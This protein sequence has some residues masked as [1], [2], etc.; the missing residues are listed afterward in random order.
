MSEYD[1]YIIKTAC[2]HITCNTRHSKSSDIHTYMY[3]HLPVYIKTV[4]SFLIL[5]TVLVAFWTMLLHSGMNPEIKPISFY[6]Q[7]FTEFLLHVHILFPVI[8]LVISLH[9][10]LYNYQQSLAVSTEYCIVHA[11][12]SHVQR[13]SFSK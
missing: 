8:L 2:N 11:D 10:Y 3:V 5:Q 7:L 4:S 13:L 6:L 1:I 9:I 12:K